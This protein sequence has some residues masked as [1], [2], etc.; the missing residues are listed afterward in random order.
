M[1]QS[2]EVVS[3]V[4]CNTTSLPE[5]ITLHA[6]SAGATAGPRSTILDDV[7]VNGH[8]THV[9]EHRIVLSDLDALAGSA[10]FGERV[11]VTVSFRKAS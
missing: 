4:L 3:I 5:T 1:D 8:E 11:T 2:L 10:S 9:W 6:L 7:I